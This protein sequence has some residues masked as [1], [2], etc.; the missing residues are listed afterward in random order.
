MN[1]TKSISSTISLDICIEHDS[2]HFSQ[3]N[4]EL[5]RFKANYFDLEAD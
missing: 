2:V 4:Y 3:V 1:D 5:S